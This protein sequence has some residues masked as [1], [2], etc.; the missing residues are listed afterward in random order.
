[1]KDEELI[2]DAHGHSGSKSVTSASIVIL[3]V[4]DY[5]VEEGGTVAAVENAASIIEGPLW[6]KVRTRESQGELKAIG[7]T[8]ST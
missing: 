3:L 1:M 5:P 6:E 8:A 4:C 7:F 2:K